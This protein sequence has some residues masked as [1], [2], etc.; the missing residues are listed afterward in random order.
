V[1]TS[2][3]PAVRRP[4]LLLVDDHQDLLK[5]WQRWLRPSCEI[6]GCVSNGHEALELAGELK[7]D[8]I[9]LDVF[10]PG[11]N[12]VEVLREI[13]R[14]TP[15]TKVLLIS[16]ADNE[17]L[18]LDALRLGASAFILKASGPNE[19]DRAIQSALLGDTYFPPLDSKP[20][21]APR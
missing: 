6:V 10:M 17:D 7:P 9:V 1:S 12:G 16:A 8:V 15:E 14:V 13:K 19:L 4:R 3:A 21:A 2:T 18:R 5:A 11:L 20:D